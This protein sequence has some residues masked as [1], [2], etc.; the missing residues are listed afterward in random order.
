MKESAENEHPDCD[1]ATTA[2]AVIAG[3]ELMESDAR[4]DSSKLNSEENDLF[5]EHVR[6]GDRISKHRN[7]N[8]IS[9]R[10]VP[11]LLS[12]APL[13][14]GPVTPHF[15]PQLSPLA[16][17]SQCQPNMAIFP[18]FMLAPSMVAEGS[19]QFL[20]EAMQ[21]AIGLPPILYQYPLSSGEEM[22][23]PPTNQSRKPSQPLKKRDKHKKVI[24]KT[25]DVSVSKSLPALESNAD[26]PILGGNPVGRA[27]HIDTPVKF[28]SFKKKVD[29][30]LST[31]QNSY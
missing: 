22:L 26:F 12:G 25:S 13:L 3:E 8:R 16:Y 31:Q 5:Q 10:Q 19:E 4:K 21:N 1:S 17:H 29:K 15:A 18:T 11:N 24:R 28:R 7:P 6:S 27:A 20:R 30:P 9:R 23:Y 14:S 2:S